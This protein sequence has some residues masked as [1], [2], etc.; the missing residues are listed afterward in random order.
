MAAAEPSVPER[1][2]TPRPHPDAQRALAADKK[3][4]LLVQFNWAVVFFSAF[5]VFVSWAIDFGPGMYIMS[6]NGLLLL[7]N[8]FYIAKGGHYTVAANVY[9]CTNT[10]IAVAGCTYFSGGF[11]IPR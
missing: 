8:L 4:A 3:V 10:L 7:A 9:L 5:Y 6:L 2:G 1:R 11:C